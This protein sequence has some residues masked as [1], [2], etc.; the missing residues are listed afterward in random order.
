MSTRNPS[1]LAVK[2]KMAF[3]KMLPF[4]ML[5]VIAAVG[6]FMYRSMSG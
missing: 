1:K 6:F 2:S 3:E 4:I 5:F